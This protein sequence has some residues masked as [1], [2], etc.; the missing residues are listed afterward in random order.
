LTHATMYA[1]VLAKIGSERGKLLSQTKLK[2]L[3]ENT[4]LT[5]LA[6]QL[7]ETSYQDKIAKV[8]VPLSSRK[9]ERA[10]QENLIETWIE[11]IR[12]GP[13]SAARYLHV[14]L[15]RFEVENVKA[16]IKATNAKFGIAQK[17]SLIYLSAEVSPKNLAVIEEAAK[18]QD[19]KQ[20]V[21]AFV[22]TEYTSALNM[23]FKSYEDTGSIACLDILLDKLFYERL[24][25]AYQKL[26]KKEKP[27]ASFYASTENDGFTL[28]TLLRG[29]NLNYD[30]NWLRLA[31]PHDNFNIPVKTVA[32]L[33]TAADFESALK[34]VLKSNYASFFVKSQ[35]PEET[36]ANA[37]K[38]F[39]KAVVEHAKKSRI[40]EIFN[41]G[42]PLAFMIQKEA[43]VHNLNALSVGVEAALKPE[44]MQR[45]LLL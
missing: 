26:P 43:E 9:L 28:L 22:N 10:F 17:L 12:N 37:E 32:A 31:V 4:K 18:A 27:H 3:T 13:Q 20:L 23:G 24:Y 35:T 33:L 16:L 8:P 5:E 1:S 42:A 21:N 2:A 40:V 45:Q 39:R 29:K 6:T 15:F 7:R 41:I 36:I 30:A 38:A 11:I 14:Y 25:A 44:D 19:L 34:I